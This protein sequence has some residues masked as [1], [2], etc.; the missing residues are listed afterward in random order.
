MK[1]IKRGKISRRPSSPGEVLKDIFLDAN[2]ISQTQFAKD[3]SASN[4]G[5]GKRIHDEDKTKRSY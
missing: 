5:Q 4:K 1:T 2:G 3:L